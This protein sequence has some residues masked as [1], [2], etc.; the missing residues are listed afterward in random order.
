MASVYRKIEREKALIA[1]AT[2]MRQST[3]NPMVQQR[4]D[5]NIREGQKNIA[6]LEEK[7]RELEIRKQSQDSGVGSMP[8]QLPPLGD[9]DQRRPGGGYDA[10]PT[11]P[12]KDPSRSYF[13]QGDY[14]DPSPGGYTQGGTGQMPSRAPFSDPRP[15]APV[16]K[17]RPNYSKLGMSHYVEVGRGSA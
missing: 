2:N 15:F 14:G 5:S 3:S 9:G 11:P 4:V 10:A 16:P 6:Y 1:A 7:M 17:A 8:P 12:P 13:G